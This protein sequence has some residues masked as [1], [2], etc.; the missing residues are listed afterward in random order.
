MVNEE[1]SKMIMNNLF[2]QRYVNDSGYGKLA[3]AKAAS[4]V[5]KDNHWGLVYGG[6]FFAGVCL[7]MEIRK[8]TG[9]K[10]SLDDVMRKL[11]LDFGGKDA[12]IDQN[13]LIRYANKQGNTDF[14][15]F[16]ETYIEGTAAMPLQ[17]YFPHAGMQ[18]NLA[19]E[20]LQLSHIPEKTKLQHQIWE[21]F[22][23][24]N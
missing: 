3:P 10:T 15:T 22:L 11:Y 9:N 2:Y 8:N 19:E 6:G 5:V 16:I 18:V 24:K 23:G 17:E 13:T 12:L 4:G 21:G 20:Q 14:K 1:V 7:D